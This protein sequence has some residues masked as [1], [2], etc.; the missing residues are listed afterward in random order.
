MSGSASGRPLVD[1]AGAAR[2]GW[3][4]ANRCFLC[5]PENPVGLW[6][7]FRRIEDGAEAD[8][9]PAPHQVGWEGIIHGGILAALLDDA[10]GNALYLRGETGVT[11]QMEV[12]FRRPVRPGDQ[13]LVRA[14]I[15]EENRRTT[16]IEATLSR[17][18]EVASSGV[19]TY[20]R[21]ALEGS[22]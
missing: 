18:E 14:R 15:G 21:K 10:M 6:L 16:T 7:R 8:F 20:F 5:G 9:M 12:R 19:G 22:R 11:V 13:L 2:S 3:R 1:F 4:P 17:D